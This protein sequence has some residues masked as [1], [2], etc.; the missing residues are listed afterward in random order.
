MTEKSISILKLILTKVSKEPEFFTFP[1]NLL[2]F[3]GLY[4][5]WFYGIST[6]V[7]H[8]MQK[9]FI[10]RETVLFQAIKFSKSTQFKWQKQ[11]YLKEFSLAEV[12]FCVYT[13]LNVKTDLFQTIQF[14]ISTHFSSI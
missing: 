1:Q 12:Q 7:G 14:S 3:M 10:Y 4:L 11:F 6:I 8:L 5:V 2:F 13:Q 9:P